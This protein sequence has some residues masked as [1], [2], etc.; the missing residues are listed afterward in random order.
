[1]G[2]Q[3]I[4]GMPFAQVGGGGPAGVASRAGRERPGYQVIWSATG[5]F[6]AVPRATSAKLAAVRRALAGWGAT[7]VVVPDQEG[8]PRYQQGQATSFAVGLFTAALGTR[9]GYVDDAWVWTDVQADVRRP[10]LSLAISSS[11]LRACAGSANY[12]PGPP[13][14]VPDCVLAASGH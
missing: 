8:L 11:V 2:W 10:Y 13:E 5:I 1:L 9:P 4:E 6:G 14:T 7:T 12:R 3:A